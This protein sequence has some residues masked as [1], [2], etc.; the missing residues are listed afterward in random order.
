MVGGLAALSVAAV[1]AVHPLGAQGVLRPDAPYIVGLTRQV[2]RAVE[3]ERIRACAP[4]VDPL[5]E[6]LTPVRTPPAETARGIAIGLCQVVVVPGREVDAYLGELERMGIFAEAAPLDASGFPKAPAP[7]MREP[8]PAA[9][10]ADRP[11]RSTPAVSPVDRPIDRPTGAPVPDDV[12]RAQSLFHDGYEALRRDRPDIAADRLAEG[13]RLSPRNAPA[14]F[15][16]AVAYDRM[17]L[18]DEAAMLYQRTISLDPGSE[19]A[20]HARDR[21]APLT[22][23]TP[24]P[25]GTKPQSP[26]HPRHAPLWREPTPLEVEHAA[27]PTMR[28]LF[29]NSPGARYR[30]A[31]IEARQASRS[32]PAFADDP[33]YGL[34][35]SMVERR[36]AEEEVAPPGRPRFDAVA[37]RRPATSG[38]VGTFLSYHDRPPPEQEQPRQPAPQPVAQPAP[39]RAAPPAPVAMPVATPPRQPQPAMAAAPAMPPAGAAP[40]TPE[41]S[42]SIGPSVTMQRRGGTGAMSTRLGAPGDRPVEAPE[43]AQSRAPATTTGRMRLVYDDG[44][45]Y[46]GAVREGEPSGDGTMRYADGSRYEGPFRDGLRHGRG[47]LRMPDG[48]I[49]EG[50]FVEDRLHG[51]GVLTWPDSSRYEGRFDAGRRTGR[52]T[53]VWPDGQRYEGEFVDG[54]LSGRGT[55]I[56]PDGRRVSGVWRNGRLEH[57]S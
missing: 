23:A 26:W 12:D 45:E 34:L 16:L 11:L 29:E 32:L 43:P 10:W 44:S 24:L 2:D 15:Y 56:Y 6:N 55:V 30:E 31:T 41:M 14:T 19:E 28:E 7:A 27:P 3:G 33:P 40:S 5:P 54:Q 4:H 49:Y 9:R 25:P 1:A 13:L 20:R 21:L 52:G 8:A 57:P 42:R 53:Y 36:R 17:G 48:M 37:I 47:V 46:M 39:V 38:A 51:H 35:R 18:S 50:E 22:F